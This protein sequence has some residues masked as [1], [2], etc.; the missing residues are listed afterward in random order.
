MRRDGTFT[1]RFTECAG[2][3]RVVKAPNLRIVALEGTHFVIKHCNDLMLQ[4][5]DLQTGGRVEGGGQPINS[6]T[7]LQAGRHYDV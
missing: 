2:A 3:Q 5:A 6:K 1:Q 4:L 7:R